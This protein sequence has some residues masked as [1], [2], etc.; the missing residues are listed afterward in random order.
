[1]YAKKLAAALVACG[2]LIVLALSAC[3]GGTP[4]GPDQP[5]PP[6]TQLTLEPTKAVSQCR[7][8]DFQFIG[9][10]VTEGGPV[11]FFWFQP[12]DPECEKVWGMGDPTC[13]ARLIPTVPSSTTRETANGP[14]ISRHATSGALNYGD[15]KFWIVDIPTGR[16]SN[17]VTM[18][19]RNCS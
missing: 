5:G 19:V 2:I 18:T 10:G 12:Y 8:V 13:Q 14:P 6:P 17:E 11:E 16:K 7:P 15:H 1:M 3:G 9:R 4:A